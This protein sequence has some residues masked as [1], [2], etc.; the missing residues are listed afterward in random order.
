MAGLGEATGGGVA[1]LWVEDCYFNDNEDGTAPTDYVKVDRAGDTGMITGC[2][3]SIA[4]NASADLKI[5]AGIMWVA[6]A[7]EAGWTTARPS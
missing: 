4:T 1:D 2:R 7:T 3:F 5:A 6:N